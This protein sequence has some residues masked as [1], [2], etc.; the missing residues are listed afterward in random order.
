VSST[1]QGL[2]DERDALKKLLNSYNSKVDLWGYPWMAGGD[3]STESRRRARESDFFI[4]ILAGRYGSKDPR[5]ET[6]ITQSEYEEFLYSHTTEYFNAAEPKP[7]QIFLKDP[8]SIKPDE[9]DLPRQLDDLDRFHSRVKRRHVLP[10]LFHDW[11]DLQKAVDD[12]LQRIPEAVPDTQYS[13]V[14]IHQFDFVVLG[15]GRYREEQVRA[16]WSGCPCSVHEAGA[17]DFKEEL[18]YRPPK[19]LRTEMRRHLKELEADPETNPRWLV[20]QP[21]FKTLNIREATD[22]NRVEFEFCHSTWLQFLA[23][24]QAATKDSTIRCILSDSASGVDLTKSPFSNNLGLAIAVIDSKSERIYWTIRKKGNVSV[25][26][27]HRSTAVGTQLHAFDSLHLD[28]GGRP[29]IFGAAR[30]ELKNEAGITSEDIRDLYIAAWGVGTRTGTP[31]IL[32]VCDSSKPLAE[33]LANVCQAKVIHAG[34]F[35]RNEMQSEKPIY[36]D[37][38]LLADIQTK[39]WE[40]EAAVACCLALN[41]ISPNCVSFNRNVT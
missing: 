22:A 2:K 9:A 25:H 28:T 12:V 27:V 11:R 35:A 4:L 39:P 23:T 8:S 7:L 20:D 18:H 29:N 16:H 19:P 38:E 41:V 17:C 31:E 33:T 32:F 14:S 10:E 6:G 37:Y 5:T 26:D 15:I 24:N 40:P 13:K 36:L 3:P 30:A 1:F 21:A 34:E